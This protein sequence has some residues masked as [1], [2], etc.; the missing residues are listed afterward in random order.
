[1]RS[2]KAMMDLILGVAQADSRV[3]A[4]TMNGS[5]V[6]NRKKDCFQDFDIV[7]YV[8][9]FQSF[10]NN[11][12]W[13]DVF[14]D[15]LY[16]QTKDDQVFDASNLA[17]DHYIYLMQFEDG[18]RIDLSLVPV[19]RFKDTFKEDPMVKVLLDKD[20]RLDEPHVPDDRHFN[21]KRPTARIFS[22]C[23]NE[24]LFVSMNVAKG[25]WREEPTY[26]LEMLA[27]IRRCLRSMLAWKVGC[28]HDFNVSVGKFSRHLDDYLEP[29]LYEGL[30][31]TYTTADIESV[32]KGLFRLVETF[33][34]AASHV[35]RTLGYTY[36]QE[37]TEKILQYLKTVQK[38][39]IKKGCSDES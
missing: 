14:G 11:P 36:P 27:I 33:D 10:L 29:R 38:D 32:W 8:E 7:Y 28:D 20:N 18:N 13:V 37:D 6:M 22:S 35:A 21:V 24:T 1:M 4:V 15:R 2:E 17:D 31:K 25:L 3:R 5:R 9:D 34:D 30:L 16:M 39:S 12:D 26:A 23:V 19:E